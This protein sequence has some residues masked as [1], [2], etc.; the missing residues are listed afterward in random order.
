MRKKLNLFALMLLL[1]GQTILGPI[2]AVSASEL[3]DFYYD[4]PVTE[5]ESTDDVVGEEG[6]DADSGETLPGDAE[7][8]ESSDGNTSD[9]STS[10]DENGESDESTSDSEESTEEG[11]EDGVVGEPSDEVEGLPGLDEGEELFEQPSLNDEI[12]LFN[13]ISMQGDVKLASC[14]DDPNLCTGIRVDQANGTIINDPNQIPANYTPQKG[15]KVYLSYGFEVDPTADYAAGSTFTFQL[16][17]NLIEEYT[18]G[19]FNQTRT[20]DSN[21]YIGYKST[22]D[23]SSKLV[24]VELLDDL[25]K[26]ES[27]HITFNFEAKFG[28][29]ADESTLEQELE[30]PLLDGGN[31][32]L[33]FI[34]KPTGAGEPIVKTAGNVTR[35]ADGA[36]M[37]WTIW[38][39]TEG[40]NIVSGATVA[41][42]TLASGHEFKTGSLTIEKYAVGL[43][44]ID[45]NNPG[46]PEPY[47]GGSTAFPVALDTGYYAYKL[48]YKTKVSED[49]TQQN[50]KYSNKATF[51]NDGPDKES[52]SEKWIE[53]GPALEKN[54]TINDKYDASWEIKYNWLGEDLSKKTS[55]KLT[56]SIPANSQGAKHEIQYDANFK[57]SRVTLSADGKTAEST[58]PLVAGTGYVLTNKTE[59]GFEID[60]KKD[61]DN[62][63]RAAYL[64][65]YNTELDQ[66][67]VTDANY[68]DIT[69]TVTRGDGGKG[70]DATVTVQPEIFT[71]KRGDID[72]G[73]K[74]ITWELTIKAE[75]ALE[76]FVIDDTIT[77]TNKA[78]KMLTHKL[79]LWGEDASDPTKVFHITGGTS[80]INSGGA[81]D[82]Q[83]FKLT[84]DT[85]AKNQTVTIKYKTKYDVEPNGGVATSYNNTAG[86][87][88]QHPISKEPH[89]ALNRT[90]KYEPG[91]SSP[92]GKNGYK[93]DAVVDNAKQEFS[94]K[95]GV[96]IN[97]EDING[98]T[99][100]DTLGPGHELLIEDGKTL[101]DAITVRL[102]KLGIN[103]ETGTADAV[104]PKSKWDVTPTEVEID[105]KVKV[106]GFILTFKGLSTG[107]NGENNQAYL[108]EYKTKDSDDV[109]GNGETAST[110]YTNS[111]VLTTLNSGTYSYE[112]DATITSHANK[113]ITKTA[114]PQPA[115][116]TIE[117]TVTV[118]ESNSKLGNITLTDKHSNNQKLLTNTFTKQEIKLNAG[119]TTTN[120]GSA[121]PVDPS[122]IDVKADG[123]FELNLGELDGKGYIIKYK[124]YFMGDPNA[125]EEVSNTASINYAGA[126]SA[127]TSEKGEGKTQFKYSSSDTSA[128]PKKGTLKIKK[129]GVNPNTGETKVLSGVKFE[130]LSRDGQVVV[131]EG[132]TGTDGELTFE[133]IRYGMYKLR[134]TLPTGTGYDYINPGIVDFQMKD[135]TNFLETDVPYTI[136]NVENVT[137]APSCTKFEL[138]I[139]DIDGNP[140]ANQAIQLKDANGI[141]KHTGTTDNNGVIT[142]PNAVQ[143]GKYDVYDGNDNKLND[144]QITVKYT[145][146][147]KDEIAPAPSCNVFTITVEDDKGV[148][149]QNLDVI[150]EHKDDS[151]IKIQ[152]TTN[153]DGKFTVPSVSTKAGVYKVYEGKQYLGDVTI[154][155][156]MIPCEAKVQLAPT[157]E[158]FTLTVND[159]DGKPRGAG[160]AIKIVD[161]SDASNVHTGTTDTDGKVNF[162]SPLP[163]G[164]YEVYEG[165][166]TTPF[167]E[168]ITNTDCAASV[169]PA[170]VCTDFTITVRDGNNDVREKVTVTL[171]DQTTG[172]T[173]STL[174]T[175]G[176]GQVKLQPNDF[177]SAGTYDVYDGKFLIDEITITYLND[178]C[179]AEVKGAPTCTTF[180]LTV[181]DRSNNPRPNVDIIVKDAAGDIVANDTTNT[182]GEIT[183]NSVIERGKY[184]VYEVSANGKEKEINSFT[185]KDDC[186]ATVKPKPS[187]GGGGGVGP[188]P[189]CTEF[190]LTVKDA[191]GFV[192]GGVDVALKNAA[193]TT[194][195]TGK[196]NEQGQVSIGNSLLMAGE[197]TVFEG[198]V[199]L[200]TI[201]IDFTEGNC[202]DEVTTPAENACTEFTITVKDAEGQVRENVEVTVKDVDGTVVVTGTTDAD[203]KITVPNTV[204]V[205]EYTVFEGETELGKVTVDF[206][207]GNCQGEVTTP[208]EPAVCTEFTITVKD[209]EGKVRENVEVTV[210][211]AD[212]KVVASGT[213]DA[214]GKIT[215]PNTVPTGDYTVF[216]GDKELGKVKVDFTEGN[217]E[218]VVVKPNE[219]SE[220]GNPGGGGGGTTPPP[221]DPTGNIQ[222]TKV[223]AVD[224]DVKLAGAKFYIVDKDNKA[225]G[226]LVTDANGEAVSADLSLGNYTL[227]EFEAPTGYELRTTP[228]SVTIDQEAIVEITVKNTKTP[229]DGVGH[230]KVTKVDAFELYKKLAGAKFKIEDAE[231]KV[232]GTLIT[233]VNG[234]A[235]SE[236]LPFGT[237]NVIEIEAPEGY[238]L[239]GASVRVTIDKSEIVGITVENTKV[240]PPGSSGGGS[241]G[242]TP[243][244][245]DPKP[246]D[247]VDP[248]PVT[249]VDPV[250]PIDPVDPP[251]N[252]IDPVDP[253]D[254]ANPPVDPANPVD[255]EGEDGVEG[256]EGEQGESGNTSKEPD[257]S[258][259]GADGEKAEGGNQGKAEVDNAAGVKNTSGEKLPQ[260]GEESLLYMTVL[261]FALMLV[262]AALVGRRKKVNE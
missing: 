3:D 108:I 84:F 254:P 72:R 33:D 22:Y 131:A 14:T 134:E 38:V 200:G 7:S 104:L 231:G 155:Y 80:T 135:G 132:V 243:P 92:T 207:D 116:D 15:D 221:V 214:A 159:V 49:P 234:E 94:W 100:K 20:K 83:A 181:N 175:D 248:E 165:T 149:R 164:E 5:S 171:K 139:K 163:A 59:T 36:E 53:Y 185:V 127:G 98:A 251:V 204:P 178:N 257:E 141:V 179:G 106:T 30:M 125:G 113:L 199:E 228:V 191:E 2:A 17:P 182:D 29:F 239:D 87:T 27:G 28:N 69:N 85:I 50:M 124:T 129:Q 21:G 209:A 161:T 158:T 177:L 245:V 188:G 77:T 52:P 201:T 162:T 168:F 194:V 143:A 76:N 8:D 16:P 46:T 223:D 109:Y 96:N 44:G 227:V 145:D 157:C 147:C 115:S 88:W 213:T 54:I 173:V 249:P 184:K 70:D 205:G 226:E 10:E 260:T 215:V 136:T 190:T 111:A 57:V 137:E 51:T 206:T 152:A 133:D 123:S 167:A 235:V 193:G 119:G 121:V 241:G 187:T 230:I 258:V 225:I 90:D 75:Q 23:S 64:I 180:T 101:D 247:P 26:G 107:V 105:G 250:D 91:D 32:E 112:S 148:G 253:I 198:D 196:T 261:G 66:E 218:A 103:D 169:Q 130:L 117:W 255:P 216:E 156:K 81:V 150:L 176:N 252:P 219:P 79:A 62:N 74:L 110:K 24:T 122:E 262:G 114:N 138:T 86:A 65:E 67:Y 211:D 31:V 146:G 238:E 212:G 208:A 170:P 56:D 43:N 34:F 93:D 97:K 25:F 6:S 233:D 78:G 58:T 82:D 45:K 73:N 9:E 19:S 160:V 236:E 120:V 172:V 48:T 13:A 195:L 232:V 202:K 189:A 203:G 60:F 217:C 71:K 210:K 39:N 11:T 55:Q 128:S 68:G 63:P 140:V 61:V 229:A 244:T 1:I 4:D 151:T 18:A 99:L 95:I 47:N 12:Q 102:L 197:Y 256:T 240:L 174:S 37:E 224:A 183:L 259:H 154:T 242:G 220:P 40:K 246:V 126:E 41:D 89:E 237:Y 118:N 144:T 222:I 166:S 42:D 153:Q 186:E 142:I 192:R 35:A